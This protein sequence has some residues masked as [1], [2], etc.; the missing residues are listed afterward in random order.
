MA[1]KNEIY[2]DGL[3]QIHIVGGTVRMDFMTLEPQKD[4]Q[5]PVQNVNNRVILPIQAFLAAYDTMQKLL[6]KL[7][8]DGLIKKKR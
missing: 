7:E 3:C 4:N 6:N 2:A 8:S 5:P 1:D